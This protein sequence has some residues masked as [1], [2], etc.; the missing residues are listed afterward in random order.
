MKNQRLVLHAIFFVSAVFYYHTNN[1]ATFTVTHTNDSGPG[2]LREAINQVNVNPMQADNIVFNIPT[3]DPNYDAVTGV[4]TITLST[5]LPTINSISVSIDGSTQTINQGNTNPFGP[6]IR[7]RSTAGH[8]YC[9]AFPLSGGSL[10]GF[11]INGFLYAVTITKFLTYPNGSCTVSDCYIGVNYNATLADANDIGIAI[12]DASN[13][14]I[15]DNILS[16]NI[17]TGIGLRKSNNNIIRGNK[18]GTDRTAMFAISNYY[19]IA[20]D[21]SANNIIGGNS[22]TFRNIIGGNS[23]AGIAINSYLSTGNSIKGN[24]IGINANG[25]LRSDT[26]SN[27]YGIAINESPGNTIGGTTAGERNIISGNIDAGIA[28]L[29]ADVKN[30]SIKGNYIGTNITGSDSIPNANG[31]LISGGSQ[32]AIGGGAAG[33]GNVISGNTLAGMVLTYSGTRMNTI[34]GNLIGTNASGTV[35]L[36]NHTGIYIKSNANKNTV[37]GTTAGERNIISGNIEMGLIVEASDSNIVIGNYIGP[38]ITGMNAFKYANDTLIQANGLMFNTGSKHNIAG[39][40]TAG[41]RNI[42]SGNRIYGHDIYGN[43]SYNYTIGNYIGVDVTGNNPLPNATGICVDGGSHHNPFINN[44]LSGNMAYGMFIVTTGS[45]YNELKGN[46]IGTNASGTAAV[47]NQIGFIFGGGTKYNTIGGTT[48]ADR[49]IISGNVFA[50]IELADVGT[51]FN[52]IIGNYIGTDVNGTTAIPN[53]HG[54]GFAS[55]PSSNLVEKNLISGNLEI[56]IIIYESSDSNQVFSNMIGV[57]AD[58]ITPLPNR[59]AGVVITLNATHNQIGMPDKGNIIAYNDT[60][61]VVV[62]GNGTL[63]NTISANRIFANGIMDIDLEPFG[64]NANDGGDADGGPNEGMNY[65]VIMSATND[66][67]NNGIF[68]TGVIDCNSYGGPAGIRIELFK[69]DAA[70]MFNHGG[71][72]TYLGHTFSGSSGEWTFMGTGANA[73]DEITATATDIMGNT[74]EFAANFG[75]VISVEEKF[76]NDVFKVYPNPASDQIKMEFSIDQ[77]KQIC[78]QIFSLDGKLITQLENKIFSSGDHVLLYNLSQLA[79][80]FY[81]ITLSDQE[82]LIARKKIVMMR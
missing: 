42:I 25:L 14:T 77:E 4:F 12:L 22:A 58:S 35:S 40:Y 49:N 23:Y 44:V 46:R 11:I 29:G 55:N 82:G 69:S 27:Y 19:G 34:K 57:A 10:N 64:V 73:G 43:S 26:I 48:P 51:S 1:A 6:E 8:T 65:P 5:L 56:G 66:T 36:S 78:I 54:I 45:N 7:V 37:G 60:A 24:Y 47:P 9:F 68:I 17:T 39:G 71:A 2:S 21:S 76:L 18:I 79:V 53:K 61:G 81:M 30:N 15:R 74:S 38:D 52:Q 62:A 32:N 31:I 50:G 16:G 67:A 13:N 80:G 70:N 33:E 75:M 72:I 41:E 20:I 28:M 59:R 3:S 63:F